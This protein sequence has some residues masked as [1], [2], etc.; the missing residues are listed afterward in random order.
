[1]ADFAGPDS[2]YALTEHVLEALRE[3]EKQD[4]LVEVISV[5]RIDIRQGTDAAR[6]IGAEKHASVVIWGW[7]RHTAHRTQVTAHFETFGDGCAKGI[8]V[9]TLR[10]VG[11]PREM[12]CFKTQG[13][14]SGD[15]AKVAALSVALA[16]Y[17]RGQYAPAKRY[18]DT[19]LVPGTLPQALIGHDALA[20]LLHYRAYSELQ[21]GS[22]ARAIED[23]NASL[24]I[25]RANA[26][27][28]GGRARAYAELK[29]RRRALS[30]LDTA[31]LLSKSPRDRAKTFVT[32]AQINELLGAGNDALNDYAVALRHD[33]SYGWIYY[34]R[35][36]HLHAL[37]RSVEALPDMNRALALAKV[38][39]ISG[40]CLYTLRAAILLKLSE[41]RPDD[42]NL[43]LGALVDFEHAVRLNPTSAGVRF[44]YAHALARF[45]DYH[46]ADREYTAS[47]AR[48]PGYSA[49]WAERGRNRLY[50]LREPR[51]ASADFDVALRL[52]PDDSSARLHRG[53]SLVRT[54]RILDALR[55][56]NIAATAKDTAIARM[57]SAQLVSLRVGLDPTGPDT[58]PR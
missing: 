21:T 43:L 31:L 44:R 1:V 49:I 30:S 29:D 13:E 48:A 23:Y 56:L 12:S 32:R 42:Y 55:D 39:K 46:A 57:A 2:L 50:F 54:G 33:R 11:R 45:G 9:E 35:A 34:N 40:E 38:S 5:P 8:P 51:R 7:Y 20:R 18:L 36:A 19:L 37:G 28:F 52:S 4:T 26:D 14:V 58:Y 47:I 6:K 27:A 25:K 3:I 24:R 10:R 41:E 15:L 53:K 16:Y 17:D 22:A